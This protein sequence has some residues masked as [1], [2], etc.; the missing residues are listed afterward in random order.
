MN[1]DEERKVCKTYDRLVYLLWYCILSALCCIGERKEQR[2]GRK[3]GNGNREGNRRGR[4]GE[5]KGGREEHVSINYAEEE[6]PFKISYLTS[7]HPTPHRSLITIHYSS[8]REAIPPPSLLP[9]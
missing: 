7:H 8:S 3:G 5:G 2:K 9:Q 6:K 1:C 4:G